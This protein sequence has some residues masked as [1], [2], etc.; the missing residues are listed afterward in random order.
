MYTYTTIT[1]YYKKEKQFYGVL[2]IDFENGIVSV[3]DIKTSKK[4]E[5]LK[6]AD[7]YFFIG[8]DIMKLKKQKPD[9]TIF[10]AFMR[11]T[12]KGRKKSLKKV[13]K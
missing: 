4:V 3:F 6:L 13:R 8:V 1:A 2:K 7:V 12:P 10:T 5:D 11:K 9:K